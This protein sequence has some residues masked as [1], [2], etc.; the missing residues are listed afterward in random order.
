MKK[1]L[2][3]L[4]KSKTWASR[5]TLDSK[6]KVKDFTRIELKSVQ[7]VNQL[8]LNDNIF[9]KGEDTDAPI[10]DA[11]EARLQVLNAELVDMETSNENITRFWIAPA[12]Q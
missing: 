8:M 12:Q 4:L 1:S 9:V 11:I 6:G 10:A 2:K 3:G 7:D 5:A